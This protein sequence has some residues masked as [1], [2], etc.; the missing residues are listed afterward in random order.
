MEGDYSPNL[1]AS[2]ESLRKEAEALSL[3]GDQGIADFIAH[4]VENA[5]SI[6]AAQNIDAVYC[7]KAGDVAAYIR[8][9][10]RS[11]NEQFCFAFSRIPSASENPEHRDR[12]HFLAWRG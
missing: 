12:S 9:N 1:A 8:F 5:S 10:V 11:T 2:A 4:S 6:L 3:R 7:Y